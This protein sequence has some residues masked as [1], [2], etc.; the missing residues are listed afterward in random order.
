[1]KKPYVE[2]SR[3]LWGR[4]GSWRKKIYCFFRGH[5]W[6]WESATYK[7]C[8]RCRKNEIIVEVPILGPPT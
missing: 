4:D 2:L 6:V 5:W 1:M 7:L 3:K 8:L